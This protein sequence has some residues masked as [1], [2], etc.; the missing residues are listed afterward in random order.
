MAFEASHRVVGSP[1]PNQAIRRSLF[2]EGEYEETPLNPKVHDN[3]SSYGLTARIE[4]EKLTPEGP[5]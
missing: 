3:N 4:R 2:G 1:N 5:H